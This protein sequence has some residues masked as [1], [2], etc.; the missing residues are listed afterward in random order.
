MLLSIRKKRGMK[1][2]WFPN[3]T[4]KPFFFGCAILL[5]RYKSPN[6]AS[7]CIF[8]T[9][10][11]TSNPMSIHGDTQDCPLTGAAFAFALH[12]AFRVAALIFCKIPAA[13]AFNR[14]QCWI[15]KGTLN[16]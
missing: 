16:P 14:Q 11:L 12:F 13:D 3:V 2:C 8:K 9:Q 10:Q 15:S 6:D 1:F 4:A 7:V 5:D